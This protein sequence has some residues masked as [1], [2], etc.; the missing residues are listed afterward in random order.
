[1]G[2]RAR[3]GA[4]IYAR[5]DS[6]E[7]AEQFKECRAYCDRLGYEIRGLAHDAAGE[8]AGWES[9]LR[10]RRNGDRIVVAS[11]LVLPDFLES[12]TGTLP[13]PH[14]PR[15]ARPAPRGLSPRQRRPRPAR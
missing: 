3:T 13:G 9:A 6:Q 12:T 2:R 14:G 11:A 10:M 15:T 7:I 1:M 8:T 4:V 5:G